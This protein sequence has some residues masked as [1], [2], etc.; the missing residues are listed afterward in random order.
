MKYIHIETREYP[1]FLIHIKNRKDKMADYAPV[2]PTTRPV[3]DEATESV[4]EIKP[5]LIDGK[6]YERFE[7]IPLNASNQQKAKDRINKRYKGNARTKIREIKD[8]EDDLVDQKQLIQF[9]AR[10]FAGLWLS[11]P[12]EIKDA[13]PFKANFDLLSEVILTQ[14]VRLDL[15]EDQVLR[16]GAIINDEVSFADIVKEEYFDKKLAI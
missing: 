10:G 15:E 9:M 16:I 3:Y 11:L 8:I 5:E 14:K 2:V 13:N 1:V 6:Y 12:Q 7:V 4:R